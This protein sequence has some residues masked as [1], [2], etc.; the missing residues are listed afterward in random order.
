MALWPRRARSEK[1]SGG[2]F[3]PVFSNLLKKQGLAGSELFI[4]LEIPG[5]QDG[6]NVVF[7]FKTVILVKELR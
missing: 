6:Y 3:E 5:F 2:V 1:N 7:F 4:F